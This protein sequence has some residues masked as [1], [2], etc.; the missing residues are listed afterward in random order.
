LKIPK[1]TEET[2]AKKATE[3]NVK[4]ATKKIKAN[5]E[6]TTLGDISELAALKTEMEENQKRSKAE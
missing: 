4:K 5:I 2:V 1:K 3:D 6:K